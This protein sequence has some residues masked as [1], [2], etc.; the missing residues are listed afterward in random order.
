MAVTFAVLSVAYAAIVIPR[1]MTPLDWALGLLVTA[2]VLQLIPLPS[3]IGSLLSPHA[4]AV[5]SS[6]S[7]LP[8]TSAWQ[9]V[10]I[11]PR[12]TAAAALELI[13]AL[14]LF[15]AAREQ[16]G[17]GGVRRTSRAVAMTGFG[18]AFLGIAQAATG[19]RSIY[20]LFP[21]EVE[22]P[23][24][25][26]PFVNRNHFATWVILAIPLCFG[27]LAARMPAPQP[28]GEPRATLLDARGTW[29]IASLVMMLL[30]LLLTL[31][32][33]A[34]LGLAVAAIV[35]LLLTRRAIKGW[36]FRRLGIVVFLVTLL[37]VSWA[38]LPAIRERLVGARGGLANR[39]VIWNETLPMVR[40]FWL[41]G[42]G[43]G[44]YET[45]MRVYQ[46]SDRTTYFNQAHNHYLQVAAEGGALIVVPFLIALAAFVWTASERLRRDHTPMWRIRVGAAC[47][48]G[49]VAVQ[50]VWET[51][52]AMTANSALAAILAGI[53]ICG[54]HP[55]SKPAKR[56]RRKS[57][58]VE[59]GQH[60]GRRD[61]VPAPDEVSLGKEVLAEE[62]QTKREPS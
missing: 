34:A 8:T 11:D 29:I 45:G 9:P 21:T 51:G 14:A 18:L 7:L 15:V 40:D 42:V 53:V 55:A 60:E 1:P 20:W 26:G 62:P 10:S 33:S 39:L 44:A 37:A 52:L 28:D 13:G 16:L 23:L 41:T 19:G 58:R 31:S 5:R 49:A 46:R 32:R 59:E 48:L 57:V 35:T 6:L 24:P 30:A 3:T 2:V 61:A 54:R 38:D 4:A 50:S 27:Y 56:T 36:Y 22:G 12:V 17:S 47:G 25:F 43:T